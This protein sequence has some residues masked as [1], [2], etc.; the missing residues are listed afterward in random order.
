MVLLEEQ[1]KDEQENDEQPKQYSK[2]MGE[3]INGEKSGYGVHT[4][5]ATASSRCPTVATETLP[6]GV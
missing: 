2:Y 6:R 5:T 4:Y 1:K 3:F